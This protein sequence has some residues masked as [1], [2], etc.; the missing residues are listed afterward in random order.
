LGVLVIASA[1]PERLTA[2]REEFVNVASIAAISLIVL[3]LGLVALRRDGERLRLEHALERQRLERE[4]DEQLARA[5][6]IAVASALSLGIAHELATPLSVISLHVEG[7]Q[8]SL[9]TAHG[10]A[11]KAIEE[12]IRDMRQVMQGFLALAR[13]DQP[14]TGR[15][16]AGSLARSAAQA[17]AHRFDAAAVA[18]ELELPRQ[19]P[20][21]RA[22]E[23]LA[24]QAITNLLINALQA[25]EAGR[26]VRLSLAEEGQHVAFRVEDE[27]QG[28]DP[29]ISDQVLR[30]FVT[31]RRDRGGSGLGLA[32]SQELARHHGGTV[33]LNPRADR[34]GTA[35]TLRLPA[36]HEGAA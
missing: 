36:F 32:I 13:G 2:E 23:T 22:D 17:V 28:V 8:R 29:A 3:G 7:L 35:A 31:T 5:E 10:T 14:E 15:L 9:G 12:Q 1:A 6:R 30:P 11:L 16:D 4:R 27:G 18:L 19:A 24:R 20:A 21:V 34:R 33:E 25:S 26:Q